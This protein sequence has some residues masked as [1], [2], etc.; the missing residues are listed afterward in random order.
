MK[1]S[2]LVRMLGHC[3]PLGVFA[4]LI[5][6]IIIFRDPHARGY[7][8]WALMIAMVFWGGVM[9]LSENM[10]NKENQGEKFR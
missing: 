7:Y 4:V 8:A 1:K 3:L 10:E 2:K 9:E 5:V 6:D